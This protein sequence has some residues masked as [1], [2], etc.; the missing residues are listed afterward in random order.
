MILK[1]SCLVCGKEY[2]YCKDCERN[3]S[4]KEI[5]CNPIHYS[6]FIVIIEYRDRV[7][8]KEKAIEKLNNL[9]ITYSNYQNYTWEN[10]IKKFLDEIFVVPKT[11][12]S[13]R[14]K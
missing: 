9:N 5:T 10:S 1:R 3:H 13:K 8:N 14:K 4:Y 7:I 6:I 12:R 11:T 2:K